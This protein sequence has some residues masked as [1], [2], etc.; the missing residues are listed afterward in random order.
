MDPPPK[1]YGAAVTLD[2][3][4]QQTVASGASDLHL[5]AGLP[6]VVRVDGNLRRLDLPVLSPETMRE[7]LFPALTDD[8]R[9][10]LETHLELDFGLALRDGPRFR[11]NAFFARGAVG[12]VFR[13]VP[14]AVPTLRELGLPAVVEAMIRNPRG[15]VLVTGPTGSGKTTTLAA[16]IDEI[17]STREE[18][19]VSVEDPIEFLH[20]PK[21]SV[22]TQREVERDT[23]SFALAL[24]QVLRQDPDVILVG[25][26]RDLETI[27]LTVTAAETGH[28][29]FGTLHTQDA[30]QTV[31]RV[32]DVFPPHQQRQ[33]RTQLA[34]VLRGVISQTLLPG[35]CGERAVA[36]EVLVAT[37][38]VRN[39]I[40]EGKTHQIRS[41]I[42][43][44]RQHGMQT[45]DAALADLVRNGRIVPE[46]AA[47]RSD[48]PEELARLIRS[49]SFGAGEVPANALRR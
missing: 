48:D 35:R 21:R 28:L 1:T 13:V 8:Q 10:R 31:D 44:G 37:P 17:N 7:L 26:L 34:G 4:L 11:G 30:P 19:I 12:A 25:E 46:E 23:T 3:L 24:R 22:V 2:D 33:V 43:T 40:R 5:S 45:M 29:V 32:V 27:S 42:Q 39:L 18:H 47:K 38:G 9:L 14:G 16:M 41:A 15:L 36:C 6:P 20:E 49:A